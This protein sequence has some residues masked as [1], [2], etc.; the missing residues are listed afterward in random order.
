MSSVSFNG[1]IR[2]A[3]AMTLALLMI[4]FQSWSYSCGDR[5]VGTASFVSMTD[6]TLLSSVD[7]GI[8]DPDAGAGEATLCLFHT[9]CALS[10]TMDA[11]PMVVSYAAAWW[12]LQGETDFGQHPG[13]NPK[14]PKFLT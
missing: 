2:T 5:G 9:G 8:A 6:S 7:Q 11:L 1:L 3:M 10:W 14:P 13:P 4:G 12:V